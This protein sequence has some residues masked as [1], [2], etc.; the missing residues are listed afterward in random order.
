MID[1]LLSLLVV[2]GGL[3]TLLGSIGLLRMR[4]AFQR[5]HAPTKATTLGVGF[6][7]LAGAISSTLGERSLSVHEVLIAFLLFITAP[8]SAYLIARVALHRGDGDRTGLE[9]PGAPAGDGSPTAA[10]DEASAGDSA[11]LQGRPPQ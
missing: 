9:L 11:N 2:A 6:I 4:D 1:A 7:L 3:F 5:M 10:P 8:V